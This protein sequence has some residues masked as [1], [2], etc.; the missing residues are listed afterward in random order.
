M[1]FISA[2]SISILIC[3]SS[4]A[5]ASPL[6]NDPVESKKYSRSFENLSLGDE[7]WLYRKQ[8]LI[9]RFGP[10]QI[11]YSGI[12]QLNDALKEFGT[13]LVIVPI[14]TRGIVH[15]EFLGGVSFDVEEAARGYSNYL[16]NL[17][18]RGVLVPSLERLVQLNSSEKLFFARDHHWTPEGARVV[19]KEVA[20]LLAKQSVTAEIPSIEFSSHLARVEDN[21]GSYQRAAAA[22]CDRHFPPEEFPVFESTGHFDLFD[23]PE[24]PDIVLVGT[25]NSRG[26]MAFN[27]DGF[28]KESLSKDVLNLAKSGGGYDEAILEYLAS[29]HFHIDPPRF[30]IW[31]VPGY[32]FLNKSSFYDELLASLEK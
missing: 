6:C 24:A 26:G 1:N 23:E 15:P 2:F 30:L 27:F 25:S 3:G 8:D 9:T 11:G 7:D 20:Q 28:L 12:Q 4:L 29:D 17:R 14:P 19:A 10:G 13:T 18:A 16:D 21:P 22:M 5:V 31:E 32:L